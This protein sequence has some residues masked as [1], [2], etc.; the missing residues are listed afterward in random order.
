L[1]PRVHPK[2]RKNLYEKGS[3]KTQLEKGVSAKREIIAE[4]SR[5]KKKTGRKRRMEYKGGGGDANRLNKWS[6][7]GEN[8][9]DK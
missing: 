9:G 8:R 7:K 4:S 1:V 5:K 2:K 6:E 3:A